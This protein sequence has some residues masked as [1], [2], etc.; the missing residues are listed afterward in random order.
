MVQTKE[1]RNARKRE[2]R[3]NNKEKIKEQRKEH[4]E[5]NKEK[6]KEKNK[7]QR[8]EYM[9]E[10]WEKNKEHI[11]EK[12]KEYNKNYMCLPKPIKHYR[13]KNWKKR[14]VICDD[15]DAL[16]NQ[17]I[18]TPN[19]ENCNVELTVDRYNTPTTRCLDHNHDTGEF[20]NVV[21]HSCNV[22]IG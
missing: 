20:R 11:K 8:K 4:Y 10:Y 21:C 3:Q 5:K 16:Y 17:Y 6:Y 12:R 19:C 13:I 7:E 18:N 14:G 2:Y 22:R 1:E 9:K 15:Y